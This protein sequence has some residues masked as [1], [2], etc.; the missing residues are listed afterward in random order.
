MR[1]WMIFGYVM[2]KFNC[3][4]LGFGRS[5]TGSIWL[6]Q[7]I[8]NTN[9][10]HMKH[11]HANIDRLMVKQACV[12]VKK[13]L[14]CLFYTS[15]L[16]VQNTCF[17]HET[18]TS[19]HWL[20]HDETSLSGSKE[21]C[22]LSVLHIHFARAEHVFVPWNICKGTLVGSCWNK[23]VLKWRK[24]WVVCF[25]R[26]FCLCRTRVCSMKHL[27]GNIDWLMMKQTCVEV[28][29]TL[30]CVFT[31]PLC[32]CMTRVSPNR[33]HQLMVLSLLQRLSSNVVWTADVQVFEDIQNSWLY[34]FPNPLELGTFRFRTRV[35]S[36]RGLVKQYNQ[37]LC[38]SSKSRCFTKRLQSRP[39]NWCSS[40]N[41]G[42][43]GF[44]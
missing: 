27:Q 43:A 28:K 6:H 20:A 31:N 14:G 11:L 30:G 40:V 18:F 32:L 2:P 33:H 25:T 5:W 41:Y 36:S 24:L 35:P 21:N 38:I 13:T 19:E 3:E 39:L 17:T 22:G 23:L 15:V 37:E 4:H 42:D 8:V 7:K 26:P 44:G 10:P 12:E 9:L 16:L 1:A 34:C 29:K